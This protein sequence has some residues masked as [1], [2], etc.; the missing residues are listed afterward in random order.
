MALSPRSLDLPQVNS[1]RQLA[2][3]GILYIVQLKRNM[4]GSPALQVSVHASELGG[5]GRCRWWPREPAVGPSLYQPPVLILERK[6]CELPCC[7]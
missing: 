2:L 1:F 5:Q 4:R 3:Y 7:V 6:I